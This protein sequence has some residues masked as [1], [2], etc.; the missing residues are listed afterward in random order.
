[1]ASRL[2][3][4]INKSLDL[5]RV[6]SR[7]VCL[8]AP[9]VWEGGTSACPPPCLCLWFFILLVRVTR[10]AVEKEDK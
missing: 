6:H 10:L 7:V 9:S 1:M 3:A 5:C 4:T 8:L 2:A